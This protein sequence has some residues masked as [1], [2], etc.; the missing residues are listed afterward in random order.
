MLDR[1]TEMGGAGAPALPATCEAL[2]RDCRQGRPEALQR[3]ASLYW[4][5]VYCLIRRTWNRSNEDAK[6]LAQDFFA[7]AVFDGEVL[8]AFSPE[9][10]SF[11]SFLRASLQ[12]FLRQAHR[13]AHAAKRGGDARTVSLQDD[14]VDTEDLAS[15]GDPEAAFDRAW[16]RV[17]LARSLS[18][19]RE[20]MAADGHAAG[21]EAFEAYE[22]VPSRGAPSYEQLAE[23]FGVSRDTIKS[24]LAR[25]R[26]TLLAAAREVLGEA[27]VSPQEM[28]RELSALTGR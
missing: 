24:W 19:A 4:K 28:E 27:A 18:R 21:W 26:E 13:D 10:G 17:V 6:D 15:D 9:R 11:R 1:T 20:R 2:L 14:G 8:R 3:L 12:N 25:A 7:R 16:Q 5:P 23:R 22:L